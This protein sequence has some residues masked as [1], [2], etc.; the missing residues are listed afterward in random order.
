[1]RA[2]R[3]V[4]VVLAAVVIA[5]IG[6][7]GVTPS[8]AERGARVGQ[9]APEITGSPWINSEPLSMAKLRGRV[10]LVEFWTYG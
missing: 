5:T 2:S 3:A 9:P 10:V 6:L 8:E 7:A 1:M 4:N